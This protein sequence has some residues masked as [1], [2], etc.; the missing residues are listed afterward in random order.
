M[1][2]GK[3][4]FRLSAGSPVG[5]SNRDPSTRLFVLKVESVHIVDD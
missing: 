4:R 3:H 5:P 2:A 1:C